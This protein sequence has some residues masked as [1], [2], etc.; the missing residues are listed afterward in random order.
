MSY[1]D[2]TLD[3][4]RRAFGLKVRDQSL[5]ESVGALEPSRWLVE[6]LANG[7]DLAVTSE[8]ARGE[9]IVAPV[10]MACRALLGHDLRI[11]SGGRLDVDPDRGLKGEC[12]FILAR[13]ESSLV[14]QAPL[15]VILE[16]KKN[17][18]EEGLGQCGAQL[19]GARLYNEKE[20]NRVSTV[21]GCVTT[22]TAWQFLKLAG[23][24]L[25]IHPE[26]LPIQELGK[27]L[28]FLVECLRDVDRE[29]AAVAAA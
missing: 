13:S 1:G 25:L 11:F 15:M 24:E 22:G 12:D 27:V 21:Y 16:A 23:S 17:D 2:F 20:G 3:G 8:K 5:F 4:L 18:I 29:A 9:F 28:W 26:Q 14:L 7:Q 6:A 10:L 19:V